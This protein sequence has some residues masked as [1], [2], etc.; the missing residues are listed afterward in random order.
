MLDSRKIVAEM[1]SEASPNVE[2]KAKEQHETLDNLIKQT[3]TSDSFLTFSKAEKSPVQW[4]HLLDTLDQQNMN[5]D[6]SSSKLEL[7]LDSKG[8]RQEE[9]FEND[10]KTEESP[11]SKNSSAKGGN[12]YKRGLQNAG[13]KFSSLKIPEAMVAIAQAAKD[14]PGWPLMSSKM[15]MYKCEKCSQEFSSPVNQRRHMRATHRR[16]LKG[17]KEDLKKKKEQIGIFWDKLTVAKSCEILSFKNLSLGEL[18]AAS[19]VRALSTHLQQ[20]GLL[21][22]PQSYIKVATFLLD[23]VQGKPSRYPLSSRDLFIILEDASEDNMLYGVTSSSMQQSIF[24]SEPGRV[25]LETKNLLSS[26]GFLV[27]L[28]LVQAWMDDKDA[29]ALRCQNALVEEEEAAQ[30][31][32]AKL[33]ERKRQKK[34][35]QRESKDKDKKALESSIGLQELTLD[36]LSHKEEDSPTTTTPSSGFSGTDTSPNEASDSALV[37]TGGANYSSFSSDLLEDKQFRHPDNQEEFESQNVTFDRR[38]DS[39][40]TFTQFRLTNEVGGRG[41]KDRR[42]GDYTYS[43]SHL[44]YGVSNDRK[45]FENQF[46]DQW[47]RKPYTTN[48][49]S[50]Q[51]FLKMNASK[52]R[53]KF[54]VMKKPISMVGSGHAVWTRKVLQTSDASL[55]D[56]NAEPA[57]SEMVSDAPGTAAGKSEEDTW[58]ANLGKPEGRIWDSSLSL[59]SITSH[60]SSSRIGADDQENY[61]G[62]IPETAIEGKVGSNALVIGSVTIPFVDPWSENPANA[63]L[64]RESEDKYQPDEVEIKCD[65]SSPKDEPA[66][67]TPEALSAEGAQ[68]LTKTASVGTGREMPASW[69]DAPPYRPLSES[70]MQLKGHVST[71]LNKPG[72]LK[73]WRPVTERSDTCMAIVSAEEQE[74]LVAIM[75]MVCKEE[76]NENAGSYAP[77][78]S[79]PSILGADEDLSNTSHI[80]LEGCEDDAIDVNVRPACISNKTFFKQQILPP[81]QAGCDLVPLRGDIANLL[82]QRWDD[83]TS[84]ADA[85]YHQDSD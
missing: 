4:F 69:K 52:Y 30:K 36:F 32:R 55:H 40:R 54:P 63:K 77:M 49:S 74:Q 14:L 18:S 7:A 38:G 44:K 9:I 21:S 58:P 53:E 13:D 24:G 2:M 15:T 23:I 56:E 31:K 22:L 27:E 37:D 25:G 47:L 45:G 12:L 11:A 83:A 84:S 29:E 62:I 48:G 57:V 41:W 42:H 33:Q 1:V 28:R 64:V 43:S 59:D 66:G 67:F 76:D 20:P 17:D 78:Q 16:P 72:V 46:G 85:V 61:E 26:L 80:G 81:G 50:A 60:S 8:H 68:R 39:A 70:S 79:Q 10:S 65:E 73:V 19:L 35:R 82:H 51:E 6:L 3:L 5:Q 71:L 34:M 75:P